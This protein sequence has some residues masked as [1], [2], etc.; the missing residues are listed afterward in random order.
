MDQVGTQAEYRGRVKEI[1][2]VMS[3]I[4]SFFLTIF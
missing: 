1:K 4:R 2:D 3:K